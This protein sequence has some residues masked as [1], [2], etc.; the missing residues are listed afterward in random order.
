MKSGYII[1]KALHLWAKGNGQEARLEIKNN[2]SISLKASVVYLLSF[3]PFR[4]ACPIIK[5]L[6]RGMLLVHSESC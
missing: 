3:F 2:T 6:F 1:S 4:F 5:K